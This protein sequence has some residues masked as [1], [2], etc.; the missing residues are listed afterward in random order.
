MKTVLTKCLCRRGKQRN[1]SCMLFS[2]FYKNNL[3]QLYVLRIFFL[4]QLSQIK[5]IS[6]IISLES[7]NQMLWNFHTVCKNKLQQPVH[8][9]T[10]AASQKH[11]LLTAVQKKLTHSNKTHHYLQVTPAS[12]QPIRTKAAVNHES[13]MMICICKLG[14]LHNKL[15]YINI[16][17]ALK[18]N[19]LI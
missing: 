5:N 16:K 18:N 17:F 2:L 12:Q 15:D 7:C 8:L 19:L 10:L 6:N 14:S 9:T 3:L 11:H 13:F 1:L 4:K